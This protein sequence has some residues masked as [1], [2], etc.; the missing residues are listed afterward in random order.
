YDKNTAEELLKQ[1]E[2]IELD[3][4]YRDNPCKPFLLYINSIYA[5]PF[6]YTISRKRCRTDFSNEAQ[7]T[8]KKIVQLVNFLNAVFLSTDPCNEHVYYCDSLS[9]NDLL[10]VVWK[11]ANIFDKKTAQGFSK[12]CANKKTH[13]MNSVRR[14]WPMN[15]IKKTSVRSLYVLKKEFIDKI[16]CN[17]FC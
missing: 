9:M 5:D 13:L 8:T 2:A 12:W 14:E 10:A 4:C 6:T 3:I 16:Y 1:V 17:Y 7:K 15:I 11:H